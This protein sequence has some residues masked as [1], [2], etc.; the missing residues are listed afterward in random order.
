MQ[1]ETIRLYSLLATHSPRLLALPLLVML[2]FLLML[3][4][5]LLLL[6]KVV[7]ELSVESK[8]RYTGAVRPT[9]LVAAT[10]AAVASTGIG[11]EQ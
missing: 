10:A 2:V 11:S 1:H 5:L 8:E 3:L 9:T 6:P 4:L 7:L